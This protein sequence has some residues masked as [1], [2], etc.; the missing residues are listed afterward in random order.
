MKSL[1]TFDYINP[2]GFT[3]VITIGNFNENELTTFMFIST[4]YY[5][6]QQLVAIENNTNSSSRYT[7]N[8]FQT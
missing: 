4:I 2:P 6:L 5:F 7:L 8:H 3:S 1:K